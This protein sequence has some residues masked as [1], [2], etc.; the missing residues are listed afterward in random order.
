MQLQDSSSYEINLH[1]V[2]QLSHHSLILPLNKSSNTIFELTF[3][4]AFLFRLPIR[5]FWPHL[6]FFNV[7]L[8]WKR[9]IESGRGTER[10]G[11]RENPKQA[12]CGQHRAWCRAESHEWFR[13]WPEPRW[14]VWYETDWATQEPLDTFITHPLQMCKF[15][16][17]CIGAMASL[18]TPF[19]ITPSCLLFYLVS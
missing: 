5:K 19:Y 6:F 7:Y 14:R 16:T 15:I 11:K 8:S 1:S 18:L 2:I 4:I 10:E 9:E 17:E 12:P 13:S 3:D